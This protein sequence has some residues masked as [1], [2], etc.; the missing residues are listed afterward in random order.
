MIDLYD[1]LIA[2]DCKMSRLKYYVDVFHV[3]RYANHKATALNLKNVVT[4]QT[5]HSNTTVF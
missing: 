2:N 1:R 3:Y 5:K 4:I